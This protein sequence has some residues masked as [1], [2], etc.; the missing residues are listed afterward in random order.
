MFGLHSSRP[1]P[2]SRRAAGQERH[3]TPGARHTACT[4]E[5][6]STSQP[7]DVAVVDEIQMLG[8]ASR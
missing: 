4:V 5:M 2:R 8:D 6:A 7:V 1:A 3:A